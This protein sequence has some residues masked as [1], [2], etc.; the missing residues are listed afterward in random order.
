MKAILILLIGYVVSALGVTPPGLLNMTSAKIGLNAGRKSAL[1]F[2][3]GACLTITF[4]SSISVMSAKFLHNHPDIVKTLQEIGLLIFVGLTIYYL[5]FA[6]NKKVKEYDAEDKTKRGWFF[7]GAFLSAL[8]LFPLPFHAYMAITLASL[9][10]LTFYPINISAY[11]AGTVLGSFTM[12]YLYIL[13]F[14]KIKSKP[15]TSQ[16]N[17][18]RII[19]SITGIVAIITLISLMT[20]K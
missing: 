11:V 12:F 6:N 15:F 3:A 19:G 5:G 18:N 4:Q 14:D 9:N 13:F 2:S 16:K 17:M 7:R 20:D 8:N 1:L 10:L